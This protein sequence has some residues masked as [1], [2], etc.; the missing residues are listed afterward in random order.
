MSK[1]ILF[2]FLTFFPL[3]SYGLDGVPQENSQIGRYQIVS[4]GKYDILFLLD[5]TTGHVWR[6]KSRNGELFSW[7]DTWVL[8]I[9]DF[10]D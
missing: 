5:T 9:K 6:S 2:L 4:H 7:D 3:F 1:K 10:Q 8:Q